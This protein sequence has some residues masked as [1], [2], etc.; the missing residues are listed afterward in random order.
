[1]KTTGQ[2]FL[3]VQ[4]M[5]DFFPGGFPC[6]FQDGQI[7]DYIRYL[8]IVHTMLPGTK[9]FSAAA[10]KQ[11]FFRQSKSIQNTGYSKI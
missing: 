4:P 3:Y 11:V 6:L 1:M 2:F 10:Q 7:S 8:K 9:E 5:A